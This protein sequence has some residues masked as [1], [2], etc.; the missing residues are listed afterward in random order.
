MTSNIKDRATEIYQM[1]IALASTDGKLFRK[2]VMG[3]IMQEFNATIASAATHYNNCKK[4]AAPIV[5][6]GRPAVS[7]T[8]RKPGSK[9]KAETIQ[10]DN[11][12]FSVIELLKHNDDVTVGRCCA[13]LMQGDASEEFDERIQYSPSNEWVLIQGLGPCHG[14]SFKLGAGE[15]EIKRYT[16]KVVAI[17]AKE[18][19]LETA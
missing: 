15:K 2:T 12:C 7:P 16:P 1:H 18:T 17:V 14:D 5:G 8:V 10:E 9:G 13:H 11:D 6:L 19:E 4:A 3:Q